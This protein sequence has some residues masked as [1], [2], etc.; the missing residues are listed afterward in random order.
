[1]EDR[2]L[3]EYWR[4]VLTGEDRALRRVQHFMSR[5]PSPPRCKLCQAPFE[6]KW[7]P[8][9]RL[10]GFKP[11]ELNQQMCRQCFKRLDAHQGGAEISVSL[12]FADLRD[13]T[14]LAE[15]VTASEFTTRLNG[16]YRIVLA[17]VDSERGVVDHMA[18][19]GVM[20]MWIP[21]FVD[22]STSKHAIAAARRVIEGMRGR[23]PI[24]VGVH[25]GTAFVGVVGEGGA[26]DFT[27]LGDAPNTTSRLSGAAGPGELIISDDAAIA[28]GLETA[29][30]RY[31]L[32]ALKG[33][34]EPFPAWVE[35]VKEATNG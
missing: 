32:L 1:V 15:S 11:W 20:A 30:L 19:D 34:S 2:K 13:S 26:K 16:F 29:E 4:T 25:T 14:A 17:A 35:S 9:I 31:E 24:G 10:A 28:A 8:M 21:A 23:L 5:L 27:A 7:V 18:G 33:K 22:Q 6:G 3:S 12:L